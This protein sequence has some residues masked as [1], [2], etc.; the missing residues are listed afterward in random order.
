MQMKTYEKPSVVELKFRNLDVI[1][2]SNDDE[3]EGNG[4]NP[5]P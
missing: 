4:G 1:V 3:I 5:D 2:T